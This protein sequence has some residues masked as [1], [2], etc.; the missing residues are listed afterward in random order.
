MHSF[1]VFIGLSLTQ[2][3]YKRLYDKKLKFVFWK[4][5]TYVCSEKIG[6]NGKSKVFVL[7]LSTYY[8]VILYP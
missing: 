4:I 6:P 1:Q 2:S 3:A 8:N 7:L 5:G